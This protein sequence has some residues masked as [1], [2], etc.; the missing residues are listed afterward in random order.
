MRIYPSSLIKKKLASGEVVRVDV[1]EGKV[2]D[3]D[4]NSAL[5]IFN[6]D[7]I[8]SDFESFCDD[9]QGIFTVFMRTAPSQAWTGAQRVCISNE[10]GQALQGTPT[11]SVVDP[12]EMRQQ[13]LEEVRREVETD[14]L[15]EEIKWLRADLRDHQKPG[16]KLGHMAAEFFRNWNNGKAAQPMQGTDNEEEDYED[17]DAEELTPLEDACLTLVDL[18]GEE[19]LIQI[20]KLLRA[21]PGKIPMI[22]SFLT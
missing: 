22:K 7:N 4:G 15:K 18:L 13:I 1:F 10:P 2:T 14:F 11:A 6:G 5:L 9:Y 17:V 21:N 20:S 19:D 8:E 3:P 16:T 12:E